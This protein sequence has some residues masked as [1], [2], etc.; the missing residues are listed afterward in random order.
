[1][2]FLGKIHTHPKEGQ[3]KFLGGGVLKVKILEG[4]NE[5]KL[6]FPGGGR[7]GGCKKTPSLG[8]VWIFSVQSWA[9]CYS[10][11]PYTWVAHPEM[12]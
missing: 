6:K 4:K 2:Q 7:G 5:V 12:L 3:R 10:V 1:M 8:G 11:V 9:G